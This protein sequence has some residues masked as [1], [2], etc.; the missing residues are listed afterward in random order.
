M[1]PQ[2]KPAQD[3]LYFV[4]FYCYFLLFTYELYFNLKRVQNRKNYK[5]NCLDETNLIP[6][7]IT[8]A[9]ASVICKA[10]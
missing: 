10:S 9:D 7:C 8:R 2:Q 6:T 1:Q 4:S 5:N 3:G